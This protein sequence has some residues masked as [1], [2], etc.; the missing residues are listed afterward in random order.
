MKNISFLLLSIALVCTSVYAQTQDSIPCKEVWRTVGYDSQDSVVF[1]PYYDPGPC[2]PALN[3]LMLG[4][5]DGIIR[6]E[7]R[8][9]RCMAIVIDDSTGRIRGI[10]LSKIKYSHDSL[11]ERKHGYYCQF[12]E[13]G[14]LVSIIEYRRGKKKYRYDINWDSKKK[15]YRYTRP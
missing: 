12:D 15:R 1:V 14:C 4:S 3:G 2:I 10:F 11:K 13:Q 6:L 9:G 5:S 7:Y 8:R